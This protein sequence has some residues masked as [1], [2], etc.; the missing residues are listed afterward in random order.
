MDTTQERL[1]RAVTRAAEVTWWNR[2][3]TKLTDVDGIDNAQ[4]FVSDQTIEQK[5]PYIEFVDAPAFH[6][7]A[8]ATFL[9]DLGYHQ[10][11]IDAMTA[12]LFGGDSSGSLYHHQAETISH[13]EDDTNDNILSVPT[14]SGKTEAFFL[15]ILNH[16]LSTTDEGLKALVLYPMKTLGVDQLNRFISYLDQINRRRDP[17]DRITIGIWD[18]DTPSRVGTQDH[19]IEVGSY[20]R[21]LKCPRNETEKLRILGDVSVGTDDNR[22][23]W[24]R[25]TR[26]SIRQ[27]VDILLTGPEALDYMFVSNNE[28]TRSILGSQ[29]G[30][31]PVEHIVFDEAHV[32]SGIQGAAISLL[33]ERLKQ[34]FQEPDPQITMV[35]A[36]VDNPGE[37]AAD[38]TST[39]SPDQINTIEFTARDFEIRGEPD[40]TRLEPCQAEELIRTLAIVHVLS[41]DT[42]TVVDKY[43]LGNA[44][45]TLRAVG[46]VQGDDPIR[47]NNTVIDWLTPPIDRALNQQL[48]QEN[49]PDTREGVISSSGGQQRI[50]ET[51]LDSSGTTSGWFEFTLESIPEVAQLAAWFSKDTTGVVE[52]KRYDELIDHLSE[53]DVD[54]PE[55]ILRT[56]MAFGR[57][58]GVVTEKYHSFLKPPKKA[59]WCQ[60]CGELRR[61]SWCSK[62]NA[63]VPEVQFCGSCHQPYVE[64]A[65][66]IDNETT[67]FTPVGGYTSRSG[68]TTGECPGCNRS[69]RLHDIEVPTPSLLS[70]MLTELCRVSPSNKTLV[71]SDSRSTAESV[72]DQIIKTEYG[73]MAETLYVDELINNDGRAN[74][75]QLFR[76]VSDRL[77]AEYWDP[78]FQNNIDNGEEFNFLKTLLDEIE[79]H[80]MLSNCTHLLDSAIVTAAPVYETDDLDELLIGHAM[81]KLFVSGSGTSFS[82]NGVTIE[83]LTRAKLL[84]RLESR[85]GFER[86]R[87]DEHLDTLLDRFITAGILSEVPWDKIRDDVQSSG[88]DKKKKD[89]IFEFI[90]AAREEMTGRGFIDNPESGVFTRSLQQD[91]SDLVLIDEVAFCDTCYRSFPATRNGDTVGDC[92]HC[93]TAVES[94]TRFRER[95]GSIVADP[96]FADVQSEWDYALDHWGYDIT[97]PIRDGR[98]PEYISVGIHKGDIP[99]TLRGAIEEGFRKDDPDVNIV[100]ATPTMELGVDIGTLDSVAQV[101]IPPTLT[102]YVQRSGRTGRTRGSSSLVLTAIRTDHPVDSHYYA[103]LEQFLDEF[104]PVRVPDPYQFDELLASHVV[105]E[106]MAYL[107]RNP[108]HMNVFEKMYTVDENKRNLVNFVNTVTEQLD[109]LREFLLEERHEEVTDHLSAIF[110]ERGIDVF[111]AVFEGDGPLSLDRRVEKT[112]SKLTQMSTEGETNDAFTGQNSRLDQW[113]QRLGYLANYRSFGQ[114]FPVKFSGANDGIEFESEGRLYDMFPGEEND[115]GAVLTL[116]GTDY[117]V[118]DVHGTTTPLTSV[119]VCD[120]EECERPFQSY[121]RS[122][123]I[124]PHCDD[125]LV[126]TPIHGVSS[127]ECTTARGGQKGYSTR[128]IQSTYIEEPEYDSAVTESAPCE[129]FGIEGEYTYGQLEVTDFVYAF[130]RWHTMSTEKDVLRSEA[131]I[132]RDESSNQSAASWRERMTD[133]DEDL[134]RPVGQQ[135]FTQGLVIRLDEST[136]RARYDTVGY[137]NASWPQA[138]VS[139]EQ[140]FK[141]AIAIV[142]EC[143]RDD[144][145]IKITSTGQELLIYIADS[146]QGG[147]GITW[148]VL[149]QLD[150]IETH[151]REVA[152]CDRCSSYCDECLLLA[153]TPAYYLDNDLLHRR[154]LAGILG[155][156]A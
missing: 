85:V 77:R 84:D 101:G 70:Y 109:I 73:L 108:H 62:C 60:E 152:Q 40:F 48:E 121:P 34:Y 11:I 1:D 81:Y 18:S 27:G 68:A 120:N 124:C 100:S 65:T 54:D 133:V 52:F 56:V 91:D 136:V 118:D 99:H 78:L 105:T 76:D 130:E 37:L 58:A 63:D 17:A 112:F 20:V 5:G 125:E 114:Q 28:D 64:T 44:L 83:G 141:K 86:H 29:P 15:P 139:L 39:S 14:A 90:E 69:P 38:L 137:D 147:N 50:V 135:Y 95:E 25:V 113:L 111:E 98:S 19:E 42:E 102:N 123:S 10:H 88:K 97:T 126:E 49:Q 132:E 45:R 4:S 7:D 93:H 96:G 61:D 16:C 22:Y 110:G 6:E 23:P 142:A 43:G 80:A 35:S 2:E 21:G 24:L 154:T 41:A 94:Y 32:W 79:S 117:I 145:R 116:H 47:L 82:K 75:Y 140:A 138:M 119:A 30:E 87:I 72:G 57:L 156:Y 107:A 122:Q 92:P 74:N 134:Y 104:E 131:V 12:E 36:T 13:I 146:R 53:H 153:R 51:V 115:L 89:Q 128:A 46:L 71:F 150:S 144:F 155:E 31:A 33:S 59:Y 103:N 149:D 143:D 55:G 26:E 9:E 151:I 8:A 127:V 67:S 3:M 129:L 106:T 148:Q 66:D